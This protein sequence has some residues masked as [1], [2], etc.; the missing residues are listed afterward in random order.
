MSV[1][2]WYFRQSGTSFWFS[3]R[4]A[5]PRNPETV[6]YWTLPRVSNDTA[7]TEILFGKISVNFVQCFRYKYSKLGK[8]FTLL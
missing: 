3:D 6:R 8:F 7:L 2:F 4:F 1:F 5:K